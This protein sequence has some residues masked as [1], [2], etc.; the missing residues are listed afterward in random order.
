MEV[1]GKEA[2]LSHPIEERQA[3]TPNWHSVA[4]VIAIGALLGLAAAVAWLKAFS[5]DEFQYAHA[6]WLV[7]H[8]QIPYRDF[9]EHHFPLIYQMLSLVFVI[10]GDAPSGILLLR[11]AMIPILL[12]SCLGVAMVNQH[13]HAASLLAPLL[14]LSTPTFVRFATEI[15]PDALACAFFLTSIGVLHT[16]WRPTYRGLCCGALAMAAVWSSQKAIAYQAPLFLAF[17]AAFLPC[18][19]TE[20]SALGSAQAFAVGA[21][22]VLSAVAT[23]LVVT[24]S[25]KAC[26]QWCIAWALEHQRAY[27]GFPWRSYFDPLLATDGWLLA[28]AAL[29][30]LTTLRRLLHLRNQFLSSPD[31]IALAA[32]PTAFLS[33]ALQRAAFPYS[34]LPFLALVAVFA[35]RGVNSLSGAIRSPAPR[36]LSVT[37]LVILAGFGVWHVML[38]ASSSNVHQRTVLER[39]GMLTDHTDAAYDNSG[40]Y[41]TRPHAYFYFYTDALLR[42]TRRDMLQREIPGAL[43]S[44]GCVLVVH[45]IREEGLPSSVKSFLAEHY[46]PYDGDLAL[47]GHRYQISPTG[48]LDARFLAV[49]DDRY[50]LEPERA[51]AGATLHIDGKAATSPEFKLSRGEHAVLYEGSAP[52]IHI[53]W[54]PRNGLR[55]RPA[56]NLQPTFSRLF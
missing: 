10:T 17:I 3:A 6:A 7:A 25:Y 50:F 34:L 23:Y 45:D 39:I 5:I 14:L 41:V 27:P 28:L 9:F 47:W 19:R 2:M 13:E 49:R 31:S 53:L 42:A 54:L 36:A 16:S 1:D 46:Q 43:M 33:F 26:W 30:S 35:A 20:P 32:L 22:A 40:G 21:G 11:A 4:S 24:H 56:H 15:R 8:G 52:E 44:T 29:G 55:W 51:L 48:R 18:R 37:L 12:L 38:L